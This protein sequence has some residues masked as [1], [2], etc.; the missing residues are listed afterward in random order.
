MIVYLSE[1]FIIQPAKFK[2]MASKPLLFISYIFFFKK[3]NWFLKK[4]QFKK[5]KY[6]LDM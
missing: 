5:I 1:N 6:I 4:K 2:K 3:L